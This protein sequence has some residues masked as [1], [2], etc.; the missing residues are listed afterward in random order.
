MI[1]KDSL[2]LFFK[3]FI[4][5]LVPMGLFYLFI[6]LFLYSFINSSSSQIQDLLTQAESIQGEA[7]VNLSSNDIIGYLI[8][9]LQNLNFHGNIFETVASLFNGS[10]ASQT[11]KGLLELAFED[12]NISSSTSLTD[13]INQTADS[14]V[15][16]LTL[17]LT[18]VGISIP[19][20]YILTSIAIRRNEARKTISQRIIYYIIKPLTYLIYTVITMIFTI[21]WTPSIFI[22]L[23][24]IIVL[25]GYIS[26]FQSFIIYNDRHLKFKKIVT[27]KNA[28]MFTLSDFIIIL[29]SFII[30]IPLYFIFNI[31][32]VFIIAIPL[33]VYMMNIV[34]INT[35]AYV[36][37]KLN[38]INVKKEEIKAKIN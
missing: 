3:N 27:L 11:L 34:S 10:F 6:L 29:I 21:I 9:S 8:S 26:L 38:R 28:L 17:N 15:F 4:Y 19:L 5:V 23:L 2:K 35:D 1:I 14:L 31:L 32:Y 25:N 12:L 24:I 18:L 16:S 37:S 7:N 20:S 13:L 36:Y 33:L 22:A 30:L